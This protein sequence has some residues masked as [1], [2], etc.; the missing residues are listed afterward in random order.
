MPDL[1]MV[2]ISSGLATR[3]LQYLRTGGT[4]VES[5]SLADL[6]QYEVTMRDRDAQNEAAIQARIDDAVKKAQPAL[7]ANRQQRRAAAFRGAK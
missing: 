7:P 1:Q 3:V 2:A 4:R 6:L 5:D